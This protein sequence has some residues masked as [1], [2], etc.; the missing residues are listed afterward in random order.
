M[1]A[2]LVSRPVSAANLRSPRSAATWS[3]PKSRWIKPMPPIDWLGSIWNIGWAECRLGWR[4]CP[5]HENYVRQ[6]LR[7]FFSL[8]R[9]GL[10]AQGAGELDSTFGDP[11]D[12]RARRGRSGGGALDSGFGGRGRRGEPR[13]TLGFD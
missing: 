13:P 2:K 9:L 3:P 6:N 5:I 11:R 4:S 10:F 8:A 1:S 12:D 7:A